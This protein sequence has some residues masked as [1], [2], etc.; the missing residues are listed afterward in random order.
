MKSAHS[1]GLVAPEAVLTAALDASPV[2]HALWSPV[3]DS[4]GRLVDLACS[5]INP[6]GASVFGRPAADSLGSRLLHSSSK[7]SNPSF[8]RAMFDVAVTGIAVRQRYPLIGEAGQQLW[9]EVA[10]T[11]LFDGLSISYR[12][13][14]AEVRLQ[15][16]HEEALAALRLLADTDPLTG[17]AN[18]RAWT[19]ALSDDLSRASADGRTLIVALLDLDNFKAYNDNHGHPAGDQLLVRVSARWK[20]TLPATATL[21]RL[22]GEEFA[23]ALPD[24]SPTT[25][26]RL[27]RKLCAQVP[28]GQTSSAGLTVWDGTEDQGSL[29]G[30]A[31]AALYAAKH[32]GRNRVEALLPLP[33]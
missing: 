26:R 29:L 30:R 20:R 18:R 24:T 4:D 9:L 13:V 12:D 27:L 5:Y 16:K 7:G 25:A 23:V 31:D 32:A 11:P 19:A 28:C 33:A 6:S 17:L 15:A 2:G 1:G 21:A 3:I 14:T 22:G 8:R 10:A